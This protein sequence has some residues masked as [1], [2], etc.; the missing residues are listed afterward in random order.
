MTGPPQLVALPGWLV[1]PPVG[2]VS[3]PSLRH[4]RRSAP[5]PTVTAGC[6]NPSRAPGRQGIPTRGPPHSRRGVTTVTASLSQVSALQVVT[7]GCHNPS[8]GGR[9]P[10][11]GCRVATGATIRPSQGLA[12]KTD[13]V[14]MTGHQY[15]IVRPPTALSEPRVRWGVATR[16]R[17]AAL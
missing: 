10:T 9:H 6:H 15:W 12:N 13:F 1:E 16:S 7:A 5:P 4:F 2:G 14:L 8:Q 11:Q 17:P 3:Q